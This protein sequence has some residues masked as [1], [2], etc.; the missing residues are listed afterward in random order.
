MTGATHFSGRV[1]TFGDHVDTDVILPAR[2]LMLTDPRELA[3]HLMEDSDHPDFARQVRPGD[4]IVAGRLFGLGSSREHAPAALKQ[5]G[6][7]A[8]I[9]PSFARI[10]LRNAINIGLP[11]IEHDTLPGLVTEGEELAIDLRAGT[12]RRLHDGAV[13]SI[14]RYPEFLLGLIEAGGLIAATRQQMAGA[15]PSPQGHG[16]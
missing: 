8:I 10:F 5:A 2:Y 6:V 3:E 12:V 15:V 16:C 1:W 13:Y 7:A 9:A 4:L 14:R 11:V